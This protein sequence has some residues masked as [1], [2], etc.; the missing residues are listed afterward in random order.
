V[1]EILAEYRQGQSV[2]EWDDDAGGPDFDGQ[3]IDLS[4]F[5][6]FDP[7]VGMIRPPGER[8]LRLDFSM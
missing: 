8:P 1:I 5:Q 6:W 3:F 2:S 4:W 7:L